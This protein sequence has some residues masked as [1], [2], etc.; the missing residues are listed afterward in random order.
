MKVHDSQAYRKMDVTRECISRIME[1]TQF[2]ALTY[3]AAREGKIK[4]GLLCS[5][6]LC[7]EDGFYGVQEGFLSEKKSMVIPRR[8]AEN[9][10]GS[11]TN[12]A[13]SGTSN[14]EAERIGNKAETEGGCVK[15]TT[16]TEIRRSSAG[17]A[18]I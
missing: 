5:K 13:K 14:I 10:K 1:P 8:R 9:G 6:R 3:T 16:T 18:F 7:F 12:C 4:T 15:L 2:T 17:D 11:G